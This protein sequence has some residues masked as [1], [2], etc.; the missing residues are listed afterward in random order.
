MP[1]LIDIDLL[2]T[3]SPKMMFSTQSNKTQKRE[4][5][6]MFGIV[7]L[8]RATSGIMVPFLRYDLSRF[9][10]VDQATKVYPVDMGGPER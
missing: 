3:R 4:S 2:S 5:Y 8:T 6:D 1:S 10:I 9:R 7:F